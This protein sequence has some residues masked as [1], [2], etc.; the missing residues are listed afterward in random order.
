MKKA[1]KVWTLYEGNSEDAIKDPEWIN[2]L[3]IV[4]SGKKRNIVIEIRELAP[5]RA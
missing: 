4:L 3:K 5:R 2:M 1:L